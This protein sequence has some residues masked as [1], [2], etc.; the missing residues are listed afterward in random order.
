MQ[1]SKLKLMLVSLLSVLTITGC[2]H[3]PVV[4]QEPLPAV[5]KAMMAPPANQLL[6]DALQQSSKTAP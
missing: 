4:I 2:C 5:T 6:L 1:L 3:P